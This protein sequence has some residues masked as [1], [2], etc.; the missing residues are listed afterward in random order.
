MAS[1]RFCPHC[2]VGVSSGDAFCLACGKPLPGRPSAPPA[3]PTDGLSRSESAGTDEEGSDNETESDGDEEEE[4]EVESPSDAIESGIGFTAWPPPAPARFGPCPL[5]RRPDAVTAV[6]AIHRGGIV[7]QDFSVEGESQGMGSSVNESFFKAGASASD[8]WS[9]NLPGAIT[10][11]S[12]PGGSETIVPYAHGSDAA[13]FGAS[14]A[15]VGSSLSMQYNKMNLS[16]G[17]KVQT[18]ISKLLTPPAR[19]ELPDEPGEDSS[20]RAGLVMAMFGG[21]FTFVGLFEGLVLGGAV[22]VAV[23]LLFLGLL[24]LFPGIY[25][26]FPSTARKAQAV[27]HRDRV[28]RA[29]AAIKN[30]NARRKEIWSSSYYCARDHVVFRDRLYCSAE[31]FHASLAGGDLTAWVTGQLGPMP[32]GLATVS[33][34][35]FVRLA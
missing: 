8:R 30:F 2:G 29:R 16:G 7:N 17:G 35:K 6:A 23:F 19:A 27:E 1:P 24:L 10:S 12:S 21:A 15:G 34:A 22:G 11:W 33:T 25:L 3:L 28:Q 32:Y 9:S 31:R 4:E 26:G 13:S 18:E 20:V 5:C 14:G